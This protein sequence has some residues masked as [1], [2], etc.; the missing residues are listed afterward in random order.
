[1]KKSF[2]PLALAFILLNT[3]DG[4]S[5]TYE[6]IVVTNKLWKNVDLYWYLV[7]GGQPE[8]NY[9]KFTEDTIIG[10]YNYKKVYTAEDT[11]SGWTN[12]GFMREDSLGKVFYINDWDTI[13][14][15]ELLY[16]FGLNVGDS[17]QLF[18]GCSGNAVVLEID[19]I[20]I[21]DRFHKR[22]I[23]D[24]EDAYTNTN[25]YWIEGIGSTYGL[26]W[27]NYSCVGGM[28]YLLC[29]YENDT[30]KYENPDYNNCIV[31]T[32]ISEENLNGINKIFISP[33]PTGNIITFKCHEI[34]ANVN[35][36]IF[37]SFGRTVVSRKFIYTDRNEVDIS[38]LSDG[39]YLFRL[40]N[41]GFT[42][43]E[44]FIKQNE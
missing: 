29:Y 30:L 38:N 37:D 42:L 23:M 4:L 25:E 15:E 5:Q 26:M 6:K 7:F 41:S 12:I 11:I 34:N 44:K 19:S 10:L 31:P 35:L 13:M 43:S 27:P 39:I 1:M 28:P 32:G 20:F 22:I 33:N 9:T 16:N 2:L 36:E 8:Y 14:N 18:T 17:T 3:I 21:F 40:T 24:F